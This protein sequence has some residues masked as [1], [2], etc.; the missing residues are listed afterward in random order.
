M[1]AKTRRPGLQVVSRAGTATL[2]VRGTVRGQRLFESAGTDVPALAEE[3][4]ARREAELYRVAVHGAPPREV[5]LSQAIL[6][7]LQAEPRSAG[8]KARLTKLLRF[9]GPRM[10]CGEVDQAVVDR[11]AAAILRTGYQPA[12]KLREITAPI[13]AVLLHAAR[14]K[15]CTVPIFESGTPARK[16]IDWFT[17]AQ[18]DAMIAHAAP[19]LAALVEFLFC[20]GARVSEALDLSWADVD[21]TE[22]RVLLR[23][24]KGRIGREPDRFVTLPPRLVVRLAA[25]DGKEGRVFLR[26]DGE[27]YASKERRGGGQIKTAWAGACQR[28]GIAG[29]T[30]DYRQGARAKPQARYVPVLTPHHARHTYASWHYALHR[31][32]L[33]LK[34]DGGWQTASQVERYAHLVPSR[35]VPEIRAFL[36]TALIQ[37][38]TERR[39]A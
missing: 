39:I 36:G 27:P 21:L 16:R 15:W 8:T 26:R 4:R 3:Y 20:T 25:T 35:L 11:C 28:A 30:R 6:S 34:H 29:V 2:Y 37:L 33:L 18:A 32:L 1:P 23:K 19:H 9:L 12:T 7:Y 31:D 22:G 10:A 24:T 5:T 17:P 14:R 38:P 13:R